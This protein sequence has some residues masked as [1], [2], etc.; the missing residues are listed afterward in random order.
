MLKK[1]GEGTFDAGILAVP[2]E[3]EDWNKSFFSLNLFTW[4]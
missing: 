1:L 4:L 2:L 3:I